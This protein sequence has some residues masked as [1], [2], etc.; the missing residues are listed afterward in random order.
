MAL[1][2]MIPFSSPP[3]AVP[4]PDIDAM[5]GDTAIPA[6]V[7]NLAKSLVNSPS[8][9]DRA[10][11]AGM[12]GQYDFDGDIWG[13]SKKRM[14]DVSPGARV[15]AWALELDSAAVEGLDQAAFREANVLQDLAREGINI[16]F[17]LRRLVHARYILSLRGVPL[18]PLP[19]I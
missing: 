7:V 1:F 12:I 15:Y 6:E 13:P 9:L 14:A 18:E 19:R 10:A 11:A 17:S 16:E 4:V 2:P 3:P 8:T 5:I